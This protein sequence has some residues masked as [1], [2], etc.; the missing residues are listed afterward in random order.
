MYGVNFTS[1]VFYVLLL[2]IS[3]QSMHPLRLFSKNFISQQE[4][5]LFSSVKLISQNIFHVE[6]NILNQSSILGNRLTLYRVGYCQ[7]LSVLFKPSINNLA[8][9]HSKTYIR[10]KKTNRKTVYSGQTKTE[11]N[12]IYQRIKR[13]QQKGKL[14]PTNTKSVTN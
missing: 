14:L 1:A 8:N 2:I 3:I 13:K 4:I 7:F 6:L 5:S 11:L 10:K 9:Y 12:K